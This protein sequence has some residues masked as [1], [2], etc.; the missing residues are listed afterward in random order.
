VGNED[1]A[2]FELAHVY[3]PTDGPLPLE[4][5]R[6][7][8]IVR[9]GF[10]RA[11]G[12]VEQLFAALKEEPRFAAAAHPFMASPA[13]ASV[14]GGWVAQLDPRLIE[15]EWAAFEL[16]LEELF[17]QVPERIVYQD[18]ITFPA[19]KE[20]LAFAVDEPVPAGEL[21]A[22]AREAAGPELR[23]MRV[24]DVYRGEQVGPGRKSIAFSVTFQ[25]PERTLSDE[26]AAA[27]RG[28]I[29]AALRERF[30]AE[31]RASR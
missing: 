24:F 10:F 31:L 23:E 3:L 30:G 6:L 27:L 19:V 16:D 11:K 22:A 8:G 13:C 12:V 18:V 2:L 7:A 5:W 14:Q 29:V 26:D 9:G 21:I 25:S 15:G 1:V 20:D 17:A 4:P 28:R